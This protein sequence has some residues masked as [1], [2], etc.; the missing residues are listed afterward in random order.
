MTAMGMAARKPVIPHGYA[1]G[2]MADKRR[3]L[4]WE[5]QTSKWQAVGAW[6]GIPGAI[7]AIWCGWKG[8]FA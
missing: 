7:C 4:G 2:S 3:F 1:W 6:A 8:A 5:F